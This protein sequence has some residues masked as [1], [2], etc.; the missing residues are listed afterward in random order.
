MKQLDLV[1]QDHPGSVCSNLSTDTLVSLEYNS[2]VPVILLPPVDWCCCGYRR[3]TQVE[4][5]ALGRRFVVGRR[6]L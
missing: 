6:L 4:S 1:Y 2:S 3:S 5:D